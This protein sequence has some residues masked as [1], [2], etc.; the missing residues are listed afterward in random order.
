MWILLHTSATNV[1]TGS[2]VL[3]IK[4]QPGL[5]LGLRRK[6][7]K[8]KTKKTKSDL[9]AE[10]DFDYSKAV[11]GKYDEQIRANSKT[12]QHSTPNTGSKPVKCP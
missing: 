7:V 8:A 2:V 1:E 5:E 10:Y 11:I 12:P 4:S 6:I 3:G 9:R